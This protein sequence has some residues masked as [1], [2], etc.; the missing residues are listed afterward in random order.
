MLFV[1]LLLFLAKGLGLGFYASHR[2]SSRVQMLENLERVFTALLRQLTYTAAPM[3]QLWRRLAAIDGVGT[4]PL[5]SATAAQLSAL[6]FSAAFAA[7]VE[8]ES[9]AGRLQPSEKQLLLTFA[10]ECGQYDL[11]RQAAQIEECIGRLSD[12]RVAAKEQF[13]AR[14][15]VYRVMGLGGGAALALLL[16]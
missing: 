14:G 15:Q 13:A 10:A 11:P 4:C 8:K 1:G 6:P 3:G 9:A 16:L 5:V 12:L 2:L 7:A